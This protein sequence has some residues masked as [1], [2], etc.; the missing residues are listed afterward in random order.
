VPIYHIFGSEELSI[1]TPGVAERAPQP[2]LALSPKEATKLH[3]ADGEVIEISIDGT[4]YP[5]PV[6]FMPTL[7][8]GLAGLPAGLPG[9]GGTPPPGKYAKILM[10]DQEIATA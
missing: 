6:K 3:V 4:G 7:P 8:A 10:F 9:L 1:L 5:L 2:Y